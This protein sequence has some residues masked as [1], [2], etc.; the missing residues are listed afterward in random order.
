MTG[1]PEGRSAASASRRPRRRRRGC[2]GRRRTEA[3]AG[4]IDWSEASQGDALY[5]LATLTLGH[6]ERLSDL[7]VIGGWWSVRSLLAA[8][9]LIEHGFDPS[10]PGCEFAV[11]RSQ[12]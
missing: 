8:P 5:D 11:L 4:V 2:G 6:E 12:R 3:V 1:F 10:E 9:W 7:D